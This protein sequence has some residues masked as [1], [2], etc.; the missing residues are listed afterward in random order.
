MRLSGFASSQNLDPAHRPSWL[1]PGDKRRM[2]PLTLRACQT[3]DKLLANRRLSPDCGMVFACAYGS[4]ISTLRFVDSIRDHGDGSASPTPFT[5]SVHNATGGSLS[6]LLD[7]HGPST[8]LSEGNVSTSAALRWAWCQLYSQRCPQVLLVCGEEHHPWSQRT[9]TGLTD[10]LWPVADGMSACLLE[11]LSGNQD[12]VWRPGEHPASRCLDNGGM[13]SADRRR[14]AAA[15]QGQQ[16]LI[17]PELLGGWWPT[18]T[19]AALPSLDELQ[20]QALQ[21]RERDGLVNC[22]WWLGPA[23]AG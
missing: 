12:L 7:L 5:S 2:D 13:T 17:A 8:T 21:V 23:T 16:R 6:Q 22:S 10:L 1:S 14:L 15:A 3:V 4:I 19:L 11:P 18:C 20:G 9:V